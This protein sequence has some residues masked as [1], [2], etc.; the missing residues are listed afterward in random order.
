MQH[1]RRKSPW[2]VVA[3]LLALGAAAAM[4]SIAAAHGSHA[5]YV[6]VN[7]NTT[8]TNTVAGFARD[9]HGHLTPL[10]HSPFNAGGAGTGSGLA[11]QGAIQVTVTGGT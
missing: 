6:Y 10:R 8:G 2:T 9:G 11:S 5:G 1:L 4:P 7:D 3:A